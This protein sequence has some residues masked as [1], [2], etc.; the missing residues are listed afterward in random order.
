MPEGIDK[1]K[2]AVSLAISL[3]T[4]LVKTVKKKF[5]FLDILAFVD[6]LRMLAELIPNKNE[7]FLQLKD[8]SPEERK[9]IVEH[10]KEEFDLDNEQAE[11]FA[12]N[13]LTW[14]ESTVKLI[15]EAKNLKK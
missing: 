2:E 13:A 10:I 3:P 7:I 14:V 5:K 12:E 15:D 11:A 9:E 1:V 4:Q 6:E 8:M